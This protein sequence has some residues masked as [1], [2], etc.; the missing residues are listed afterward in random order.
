MEVLELA[1]RRR[2][3]EIIEVAAPGDI[4]SRIFDL[5]ILSLIILNVIALVLGTV[6]KIHDIAPL[7]FRV[8]ELFSVA[9]FTTEYL[10]RLWCCVENPKFS[11]AI[12]GRFRY[13]FSFIGLVD[14]LAIVP[15]YLPFMTA[16]YRFLRAIRLLRLFRLFKL[17][18][19]SA[20]L[21]SLEN[22]VAKRKEELLSTL[23]LL[24]LLLLCVSSMMYYAERD[25]QPEAFSSIPMTMWWGV[26]T[27]TTVG[28]GDVYPITVVGKLLGACVAILGI[29]IFALPAG[30]IGASYLE[31]L[32]CRRRTDSKNSD[33]ID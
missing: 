10:M 24:S 19:Y 18:R 20:A 29:G 4:K 12:Q 9:V 22:V 8:F 6:K 11:G 15:F 7:A 30:I 16:D 33:L 21:A 27:L 1:A 5:L 14:L 25:A 13:I 2:T 3:Y 28:Y 26:A 17:V 31:E 32:D 23:F